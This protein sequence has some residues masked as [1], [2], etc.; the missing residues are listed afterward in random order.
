[1]NVQDSKQREYN[2][3]SDELIQM[4]DTLVL[5][6]KRTVEERSKFVQ[7]I[8]DQGRAEGLEDMQIRGL[9]ETALKKHGLSDKT[10]VRALPQ[11][12]KHTSMI[13]DQ[14][15][16][17]KQIVEEEPKPVIEYVPK[18]AEPEPEPL[19]PPPLNVI[20][21]EQAIQ[22]Q[23]QPVRISVIQCPLRVN[24]D[25]GPYTAMITVRISADRKVK[26]DPINRSDIVK[27][28]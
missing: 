10:I 19:P 15:H 24:T 26:L 7:A 20:T 12:L 14:S 5:T 11:E 28:R 9:I 25:H 27:I 17:T 13:R 22:E 1:M 6:Y 8:I 18:P 4:I 21:Q 16:R 23:E 2:N 3:P